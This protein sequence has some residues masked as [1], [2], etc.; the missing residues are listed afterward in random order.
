MVNYLNNLSR[1]RKRDQK[2]KQKDLINEPGS[3]ADEQ[4]RDDRAGTGRGRA[5]GHALVEQLELL[6]EERDPEEVA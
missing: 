5:A 1:P 2:S 6:V 4:E 3:D